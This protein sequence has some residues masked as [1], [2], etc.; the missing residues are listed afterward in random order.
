VATGGC[1][2]KSYLWR[3][4]N[5]EKVADLAAH[6][7]SVSAIKFSNDGQF[8][9]SGGMDGKI[10]VFQLPNQLVTTLEGPSE[11]TWLHWHPRGLVLLAAGEDG[12]IWM[13]QIPSGKCMNVFTGHADSVTCGQFTPDGKM[14]VT[15]STDGS[16]IVWDPKT[17]AALHKWSHQDGRF[18]QG[19]ITSLAIHQDSNLIISGAQD[20]STMLMHIA[21]S[22]LLG[23]LESHQDSVESIQ[24][25]QVYR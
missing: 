20:G 9:A 17:G 23:P 13:F 3:S 7:D 2:D 10:H 12:T 8:I 21:T 19:P 24:F 1:D 11:V 5:G 6:S 25:S 4:D 14:I 16:V 22:K 15:G 18:H